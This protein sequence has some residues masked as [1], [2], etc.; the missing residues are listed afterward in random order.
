MQNGDSSRQLPT[1]HPL[2]KPDVRVTFSSVR[3]SRLPSTSLSFSLYA[4]QEHFISVLLPA[5]TT[6]M[7]SS[8]RYNCPPSY[9][10]AVPSPDYSR[11]PDPSEQLVESSIIPPPYIQRV[12]SIA[13]TSSSTSG[14]S[15]L[16]GSSRPQSMSANG[17][18]EYEQLTY[19]PSA[20]LSHTLSRLTQST[21]GDSPRSIPSDLDAQSVSGGDKRYTF[22]AGSIELDLG[23][24]PEGQSIPSYGLEGLVRGI[25]K[26]KKLSHVQAITITLE[27]RAQTMVMQAGLAAGHSAIKLLDVSKVIYAA[28]PH[29]KDKDT[30]ASK[31]FPFELEFPTLIDGT[32]DPLPPTFRGVHPSMEGYIKYTIRVTVTKKGIWPREVISTTIH[33]LPKFYLRPEALLWPRISLMDAKRFGFEGDKWKT[34]KVSIHPSYP[35]SFPLNQQPELSLSI[36]RTAQAVANY[37]FP[38]N[39]RIKYPNATKD[40]LCTLVHEKITLQLIRVVTMV[41]NGNKSSH[42]VSMGKARIQQIEKEL[43][44]SDERV[45]RGGF[46][47]GISEGEASWTAGQIITQSYLI[48][49]TVQPDERQP[50]LF[51]H[52]EPIEMFSHSH[53]QFECPFEIRNAPATNLL[54][55]SSLHTNSPSCQST[56]F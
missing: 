56:R 36:P 27:G 6:V 42:L 4:L 43:V 30:N 3:P 16:F 19:S 1:T 55:S 2:I 34:T 50:P 47:G 28:S 24:R 33:Y 54:L 53:E 46:K 18:E 40:E 35:R 25:V 41:A 12:T 49:V 52:D 38:F 31:S 21:N 26:L 22:S 17:V 51:K 20:A 7:S 23:E 9:G 11:D 14:L 8:L 44:G 32:N 37:C 10:V 15:S 5:S 29:N 48:R 39:V 45:I 13:S